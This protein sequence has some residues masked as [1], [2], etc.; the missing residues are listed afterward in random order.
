MPQHRAMGK[1]D[2]VLHNLKLFRE[3]PLKSGFR[4]SMQMHGLHPWPQPVDSCSDS[5]SS[6]LGPGLH[7]LLTRALRQLQ[8]PWQTSFQA[9]SIPPGPHGSLP[10]QPVHSEII[11]SKASTLRGCI[12]HAFTQGPTSWLGYSKLGNWHCL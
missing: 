6:S 7:L 4:E 12:L 10:S 5:G 3:F 2:W 1:L 8:P 9:S 11:S